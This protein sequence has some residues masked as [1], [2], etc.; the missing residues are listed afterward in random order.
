LGLVGLEVQEI[1]S[2]RKE[3]RVILNFA[4]GELPREQ[5]DEQ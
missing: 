4:A 3:R 5:E 2:K 1:R